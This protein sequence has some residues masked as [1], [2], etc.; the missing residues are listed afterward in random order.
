M[1]IID[2]GFYIER[3]FI[4]KL[5]ENMITLPFNDMKNWLLNCIDNF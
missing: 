3:D 4:K 5:F 1:V 2:K